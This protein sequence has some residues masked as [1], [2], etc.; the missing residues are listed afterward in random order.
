MEGSVTHQNE[1]EGQRPLDWAEGG[2][3]SYLWEL[4]LD[5]TGQRYLRIYLFI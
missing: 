5:A 2:S 4:F 1:E 3:R